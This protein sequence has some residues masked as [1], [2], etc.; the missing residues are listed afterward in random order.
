MNLD[1]VFYGLDARSATVFSTLKEVYTA[2]KVILE[3]MLHL[4]VIFYGLDACSAIASPMFNMLENSSHR[5]T[6]T[7]NVLGSLRDY[8]GISMKDAMGISV[9]IL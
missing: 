6:G 5:D 3:V 2:S 7:R 8:S 9:R 1:D 4:G